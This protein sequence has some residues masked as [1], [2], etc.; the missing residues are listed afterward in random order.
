MDSLQAPGD[1]DQT[2]NRSL[3]VVATGLGKSALLSFPALLS[4]SYTLLPP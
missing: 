3:T 4:P 2:V 1:G